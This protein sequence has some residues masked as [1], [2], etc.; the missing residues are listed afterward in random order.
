MTPNRRGVDELSFG[1]SFLRFPDLFPGR[2]SG[3][4]WGDRVLALD[5]AGGPYLFSGLSPEQEEAVRRKFGGLCREGADEAVS[6][7]VFRAPASDFAEVD[8]RGWEYTLDMEHEPASVRLAG[9]RLMA[10]LDWTPGLSGGLW[11][12]EGAGEEWTS[13]FENYLRV[14]TA[15]RLLEEGGALIHSAGITDGERAWLLLGPSGAGKTT[16][17]RLCLERGA[18]VL[19]DDLNAV[20]LGEDGARLER[21]PFTGDLGDRS[22][23]PS[24]HPLRAVLR[25]N[26]GTVEGTRPL[27]PAGALAGLVAAAPF[28]NR[29]PWRREALLA[30]LE[31]LAR[32]VPAWELTFSLGGR[33][34]DIL[35]QL[36]P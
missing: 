5:V 2:R 26:K 7:R 16:A 1:L 9:L 30:V 19:S 18:S 11:T 10:R 23:G 32:S 33:V 36:P 3:E 25:L 35:R 17:S 8:V 14:L 4:P 31:R 27:T 13:V 15:H 24:L 6:T 20:R 22:G 34:W 12:S 21:L 29:D 28:V